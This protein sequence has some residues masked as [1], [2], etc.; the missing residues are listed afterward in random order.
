MTVRMAATLAMMM[1]VSIIPAGTHAQSTHKNTRRK[2]S[3]QQNLAEEMREMRQELQKQIDDLKQQLAD[4]DAKLEGAHQ[5]VQNA[6][7]KAAEASDKA[8]AATTSA[9]QNAETVT[10]LQNKVEEVKTAEATDV[11]TVQEK[12]DKL[13]K[14]VE[15]PLAIHY[16]GIE[17]TPGGFFAAETTYRT[18]SLKL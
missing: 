14:S 7:A 5:A 6:D 17:I 8:T 15:S 9:A 3:S 11:K 16:K 12:T 10:A 13:A 4:R 2:T 18:R 1:A